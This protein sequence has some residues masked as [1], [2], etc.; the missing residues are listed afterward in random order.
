MSDEMQKQPDHVERMHN[1]LQ[2][3]IYRELLVAPFELS[4]GNI[5]PLRVP[6]WR[7]TA[8]SCQHRQSKTCARSYNVI[9]LHTQWTSTA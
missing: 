6:G 8:L 7:R 1:E 5:D 9:R 3:A 4:K 2:A